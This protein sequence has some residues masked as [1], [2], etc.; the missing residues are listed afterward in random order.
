[1]TIH[2]ELEAL[3]HLVL[4]GM[5][6][7]GAQH[8]QWYLGQVLLQIGYTKEWV[9]NRMKELGYDYEDWGIAP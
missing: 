6:T 1:M 3:V 2:D 4:S 8:K 7:D 5:Q 9:I